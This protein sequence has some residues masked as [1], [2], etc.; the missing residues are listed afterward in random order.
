MTMIM[1]I[2]KKHKSIAPLFDEKF[3]KNF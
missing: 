2:T 3:W 1:L